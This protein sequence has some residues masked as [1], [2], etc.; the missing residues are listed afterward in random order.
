MNSKSILVG[1]DGGFSRN[2][3]LA[4]IAAMSFSSGLPYMLLTKLLGGWLSSKS[5]PLA[6]L[7]V[8]GFVQLVFSIKI[9]WAIAFD[10]FRPPWLDQRRG[11]ILVLQLAL[12]VAML[13]FLVPQ[14]EGVDGL[15]WALLIALVVALLSAS[16]DTVIGAYRIVILSTAELG[17]GSMVSSVGYKLALIGMGSLSLLLVPL[18]KLV[19]MALL[20]LLQLV[21]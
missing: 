4:V 3:R 7:S 9:F 5:V 11:W 20:W 16:Q 17:A 15:P 12:A 18:F 8:L 21:T 1:R 10:R 6:W 2:R 13:G 14:P 19:L